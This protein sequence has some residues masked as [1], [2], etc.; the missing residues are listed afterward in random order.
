MRHN[1]LCHGFDLEFKWIIPAGADTCR[2]RIWMRKEE[3]S[4]WEKYSIISAVKKGCF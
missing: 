2:F 1:P 3:G 4:E